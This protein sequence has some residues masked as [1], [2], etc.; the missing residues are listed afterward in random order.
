LR[1]LALIEQN[2][3]PSQKLKD[4]KY[5]VTM[6]GRWLIVLNMSVVEQ[7]W[8]CAAFSRLNRRAVQKIISFVLSLF[9][10]REKI[11]PFTS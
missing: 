7:Q 2:P 4:K 3:Y 9:I 6:R 10:I 1:V 5:S 8:S 11:P